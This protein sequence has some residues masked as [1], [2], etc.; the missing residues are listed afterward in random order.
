MEQLYAADQRKVSWTRLLRA[1]GRFDVPAEP[2][3]PQ[4][5]QEEADLLKRIGLLQHMTDPSRVDAWTTWL[6]S[7]APPD[8]LSVPE[9]RLAMQLMHLLGMTPSSLASGFE[10]LWRHA[11]VRA[12]ISAL[13]TLT[14][15]ARD[16]TVTGLAQ[17]DQLPPM[18]H[19]RYTR[20]EVVAMCVSAIDK[21]KSIAKVSSFP[22]FA[23][24]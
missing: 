10:Q 13:L 20:G 14:R 22:T 3:D 1:I 24:S 6:S 5:R 4:L 23:R 12:E 19:A 8:G 9:S 11:P 18:A 21:P 15:A 17:L 2:S 16:A 7:P